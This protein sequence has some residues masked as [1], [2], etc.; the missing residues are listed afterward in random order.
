MKADHFLTLARNMFFKLFNTTA[1][2]IYLGLF[3]FVIAAATFI[4]NDYGSSTAQ[5]LIYNAWWFE[6]LL[7]LIGIAILSNISRFSMIKKGKWALLIFHLAILVILIG[8]AITRNFG[9]EGVMHIREGESSGT[10][11]S[12]E[13]YLLFRWENGGNVYEFEEEVLFASHGD[14]HFEESYLLGNNLI[15][16]RLKEFIPNPKQALQE[17]ADGKPTLISEFH[18]KA[19]LTWQSESPKLKNESLVAL[20]LEIVINGKTHEIYVFG[21]KGLSPQPALI[22]EENLRF[23]VSYGPRLFELPFKITLNDFIIDRY[24]GANSPAS[25]ASEIQLSDP[26]TQLQKDFR[27]YMNHILN[28]EGYRFFQ[29]SFD[30]D[31]KGTYLT[32]NHDS[33]GTWVSYLGYGLLTLGMIMVFFSKNT[34]FYE[35]S[36]KI[37]KMEGFTKTAVLLLFIMF[38]SADLN[39]QPVDAPNLA[40]I[41]TAHADKFSRLVVQDVNG[42]MKPMHTLNRELLRKLSGKET[43]NKLTADQVIL[44]MFTAQQ[45]WY[46]I[47]LVKMGRHE[48][49]KESLNRGTRHASYKDFFLPDGSYKLAGEVSKAYLLDPVERGAFEKELLKLD[50]KINILNMIFSGQ[51]FKVIPVVN[52]VNHTWISSHSHGNVQHVEG[53]QLFIDYQKAVYHATHS[54]DYREAE[55]LLAELTAYQ[56]RYGWEIIPSESKL[57]AEIFLNKTNIFGRLS[58]FYTLLDLAFLSLLFISVFKPNIKLLKIYYALLGLTLLGFLCHTLGLGVRWYVSGRAPWSNGYESMIYIAWATCIAGLTFSRKSL[59]G[60]AAAMVL[61]GVILSVAMMSYMD[62]EITP[63]VPVLKS[64]W[65]TIHVSMIAGSYGFLMLGA[66]IGLINLILMIMLNNSNK[67]RIERMVQEMSLISEMSLIGGLIMISIGTYLGG[68]WANE[69]W[70]RYWGWDAKE[71][72]ALVTILV[73]ALILHL[74]LIPKLNGLYVFN[75]AALFGMASVIMT[76]FGVNYYLSGLHSYAAGDPV[77]IPGWVSVTVVILAVIATGAFIKKRKTAVGF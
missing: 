2:A 15:E 26:R 24:P 11:L 48:K 7:I 74:R 27:I 65:L 43:F 39:A 32:V 30:R 9:Y 53:Q 41:S 33:L 75:L 52:D 58:L 63:L 36:Q 47:P 77:P 42:R 61:S 56:L 35:L 45:S 25:Y 49:I 55:K 50:E 20:A 4:E 12:S 40:Y 17:R 59:G 29:S 38:V 62:P 57:K 22:E 10:F 28:Y 71:T 3:A 46:G 54:R 5:K 51:L 31:E 23:T 16:V 13:N 60:M 44:S 72:W 34:R 21:K 66:I 76:Y 18:P 68:V 8:A 64:Y 6:L 69:S 14:N 19:K 70:G 1:A 73:Y 67:K 37:R